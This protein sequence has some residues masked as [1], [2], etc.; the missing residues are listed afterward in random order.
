M[1]ANVNLPTRTGRVPLHSAAWKSGVKECVEILISHGAELNPFDKHNRNTLFFACLGESEEIAEFLLDK[2][3]EKNIPI[4]EINAKT[5]RHRTPLRQAAGHG[6]DAIV[7]KLIKTAQAANDLEGLAI[8]EADT[9]KGMTA[10]HRAAWLGKKES[11]RLL[12]DAGAD[13]SLRDHNDKTALVLAYEQ[14]AMASQQQTFEDIISRLIENDPASAKSDPELVAICAINGNLRLLK[15][16]VAIGSDLNRP[17]RYGW[18]PLDLARKFHQA[19]AGEFLNQQAAWRGMLP[20]RWAEDSRT[21]I[22]EEGKAVRHSSKERICISAD[23]PL[24]AGLDSFYFEV[25]FKQIDQE[26]AHPIVAI[27]S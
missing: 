8:N 5:K 23:K 12:L 20:S 27:V 24:P 16:L 7:D 19:E 13:A 4:T 26:I 25:T 1:G 14:W 15:K 21:T 9:R 18:T 11:V 3:L 10:L 17:D 2:L 22:T 6:F